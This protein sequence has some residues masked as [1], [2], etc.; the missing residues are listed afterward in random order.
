M[1]TH[2]TCVFLYI[3]HDV[4]ATFQGHVIVRGYAYVQTEFKSNLHMTT[5]QNAGWCNSRL[6]ASLACYPLDQNTWLQEI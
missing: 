1:C 6:V 5:L 3:L 2:T 4:L